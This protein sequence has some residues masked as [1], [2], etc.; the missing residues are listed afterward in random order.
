V[1]GFYDEVRTRLIENRK[2]QVIQADA[3][4]FLPKLEK[5]IT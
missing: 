3:E 2:M 5:A 1:V 4:V